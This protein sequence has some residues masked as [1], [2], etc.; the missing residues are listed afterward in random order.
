ML[1]KQ[2]RPMPCIA[3]AYV[4][5]QGA[6]NR[7][8]GDSIGKSVPGKVLDISPYFVWNG[9]GI[10]VCSLRRKSQILWTLK[11]ALVAA[12][13]PVF[14]VVASAWHLHGGT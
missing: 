5:A 10:L 11:A 8:F 7:A 4:P 1:G 13:L 9:P 2:I 3:Y 6:Y 14:L 12:F